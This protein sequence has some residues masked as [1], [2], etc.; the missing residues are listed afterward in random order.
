[1][2]EAITFSV[3][4][5]IALITLNRPDK[6]NAINRS[7]RKEVQDAYV[8]VKSN[9]DIW[10]VILT[11]AGNVFCAGKDLFEKAVEDG[12]V[13]SN[14]ELYL[15]QRSIYKPFIAAL[16]GPCYAQGGGFALMSDV[17]IF[18]ERA[19]LGW[20]Q[21][22][23]G[24]SSVSGPTLFATEVGM[25]AAMPYLLR[26]VPVTAQEALALHIAQEVVPHE[27][28]LET[29]YRWAHEILKAAPL[30]VQAVKEAAIR[31]QE[32]PLE[33]RIPVAREIA[34]RVLYSDDS[35]EGV[36]AFKEKRPPVWTGR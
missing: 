20:P 6:A 27:R 35:R 25:A 30:A 9:P 33:A 32:L 34:N 29:A 12:S 13:M 21:V 2:G 26:G 5:H 16:N 14:D 15:Y 17:R 1:M 3:A 31:S 8:E 18:S 10:L 24:I 4:D 23:R 11:G 36:L 19:T 22:L 7:M 28:L